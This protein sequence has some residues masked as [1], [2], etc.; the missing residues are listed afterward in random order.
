MARI[1]VIDDEE[2]VRDALV[3]L[4]EHEGHEIDSAVNGEIGLKKFQENPFDLVVTDI[5]MPDK[6]GIETIKDLRAIS[7]DVR[8]IA[9]SGGGR[10][11]NTGFLDVALRL[12]ADSA[13]LKPFNRGH[14]LHIVRDCLEK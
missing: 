5:V 11:G 14:F 4:L 12:G 3:M 9:I 2:S 8:I 6:E 7:P 10:T 13:M 1:L